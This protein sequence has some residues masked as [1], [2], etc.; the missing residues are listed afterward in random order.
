MSETTVIRPS[1]VEIWHCEQPE[2]Y[3]VLREHWDTSAEPPVRHVY[4]VRPSN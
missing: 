4:E 1:H 2:E 3:R